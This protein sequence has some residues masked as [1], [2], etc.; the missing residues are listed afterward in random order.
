M[1]IEEEQKQARIVVPAKMVKPVG[2]NQQSRPSPMRLQTQHGQ[3]TPKKGVKPSKQAVLSSVSSIV[4]NRKHEQPA[5][6]KLQKLDQELLRKTFYTFTAEFTTEV[7]LY[8]K[9]YNRFIRETKNKIDVQVKA[10][11]RDKLQHAQFLNRE[12]IKFWKEFPRS[13]KFYHSNLRDVKQ[14]IEP[15]SAV[16]SQRSVH[17]GNAI[18]VRDID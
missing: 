9:N 4:S 8:F 10:N 18:E 6:V 3:T 1:D 13:L 12:E 11:K 17:T 2:G 5:P 15:V 7:D 14:A 16:Q